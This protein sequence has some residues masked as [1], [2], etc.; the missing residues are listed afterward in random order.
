MALWLLTLILFNM[1]PRYGGYFSVMTGASLI[2]GNIIW[3]A[4]RNPTELAFPMN[5]E[6]CRQGVSDNTDCV[7]KLH[8][9]WCFVLCLF[10]GKFTLVMNNNNNSKNNE[11]F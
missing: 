4:V 2:I 7:M 9:S 3:A 8:Y 5:F 11:G 6:G 10:T 1:V